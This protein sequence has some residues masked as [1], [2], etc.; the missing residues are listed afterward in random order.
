MCC[1]MCENFT[2][3]IFISAPLTQSHQNKLKAA[4]MSD[5]LNEIA[6][7]LLCPLSKTLAIDPVLCLDGFVYER[8]ALEALRRKSDPYTV[9]LVSHSP[10]HSKL[11]CIIEKLVSSGEINDEYLGGWADIRQESAAIEKA[12]EGA[13]DGDTMCMVE[14]GEMYLKGDVVDR[15]EEEAYAYFEGASEEDDEIGTA[16]KADCLLIGTG[17]TKDF[18]SG[19]EILVEAAAEGSGEEIIHEEIPLL[20]S[21]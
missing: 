19:Y 10:F 7:E 20:Y 15:D 5:V 8:E 16:R 1:V 2:G 3:G 4:N 14:L 12:R 21:Y 6:R 18:Q 17:V 11:F 13:A 9:P